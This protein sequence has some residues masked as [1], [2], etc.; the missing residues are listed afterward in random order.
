MTEDQILTEI[1]IEKALSTLHPADRLMMLLIFR[2][3]QPLDWDLK[4]WPPTYEDV[5]IYIGLKFEGKPLSEAAIRYRRDAILK[6]WKGQRGHLRRQRRD[7]D[8]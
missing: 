5:G 7:S 8:L 6:M 3:S 4:R 1:A 2:I